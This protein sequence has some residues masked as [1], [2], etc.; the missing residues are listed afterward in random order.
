VVSSGGIP[1]ISPSNLR[2]RFH[3]ARVIEWL[4]PNTRKPDLREAMAPVARDLL[5]S[6]QQLRR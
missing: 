6:I 3:R 5:A 1:R 2:Q 4:H